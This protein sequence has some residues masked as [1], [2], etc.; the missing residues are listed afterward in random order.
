MLYFFP[1]AGCVDVSMSGLCDSFVLSW[2]SS[3]S[4]C[5][6]KKAREKNQISPE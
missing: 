6:L 1:D 5:D 4:N 2:L 3:C